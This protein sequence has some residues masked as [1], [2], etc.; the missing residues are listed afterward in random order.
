MLLLSSIESMADQWCGC[1]CGQAV[2][3]PQARRCNFRSN[4]S[5]VGATIL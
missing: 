2:R 1:V 5:N 3:R 4:R